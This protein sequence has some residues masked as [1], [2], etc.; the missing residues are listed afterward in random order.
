MQVVGTSLFI[1]GSFE[2]IHPLLSTIWAIIHRSNPTLIWPLSLVEIS[3]E[4]RLSGPG[5]VW[6]GIPPS[7]T[8]SLF[9]PSIAEKAPD[10]GHPKLW[11]CYSIHPIWSAHHSMWCPTLNS[12]PALWGN[13]AESRYHK[14]EGC[15]LS[16]Q[17]NDRM[18]CPS[19]NLWRLAG[20][21]SCGPKFPYRAVCHG[22]EAW[23]LS[24]SVTLMP[25]MIDINAELLSL[26]N[27]WSDESKDNQGG[28]THNFH[29]PWSQS[30]PC[31]W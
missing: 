16:I 5:G 6:K 27:P 1:W 14:E 13:L 24:I 18:L 8:L 17:L 31:S 3:W 20:L 29:G 30:Q 10:L 26:S 23:I 19:A 7:P 2:I 15:D 28:A 25:L 11:H 12:L 4:T 21:S 22:M 9:C